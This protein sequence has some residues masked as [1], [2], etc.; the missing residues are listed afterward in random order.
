MGREGFEPCQS[1]EASGERREPRASTSGSGSNPPRP[2]HVTCPLKQ[3]EIHTFQRFY[4]PNPDF[5]RLDSG[6][7]IS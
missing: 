7:E 1:R 4:R 5:C 6:D 2:I 3:C